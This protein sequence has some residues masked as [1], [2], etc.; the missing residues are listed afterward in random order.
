MPFSINQ[1][2]PVSSIHL[3]VVNKVSS[4]TRSKLHYCPINVCLGT[5]YSKTLLYQSPMDHHQWF[6]V[7]KVQNK[8]DSHIKL[9]NTIPQT[10][11]KYSENAFLVIIA[12]V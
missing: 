4:N 3:T 12:T 11:Y 7:S 5:Q 2:K 9:Y 10:F 1:A 8:W 6:Y